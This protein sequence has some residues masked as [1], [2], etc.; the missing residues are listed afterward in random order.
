MPGDSKLSEA[1]TIGLGDFGTNSV[2]YMNVQLE[3]FLFVLKFSYH[4]WAMCTHYII[5]GAL[6]AVY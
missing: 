6:K 5:D 2:V 3:S 4:N 1:L